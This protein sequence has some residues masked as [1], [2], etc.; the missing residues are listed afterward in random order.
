MKIGVM[1]K[2]E[3]TNDLLFH[4]ELFLASVLVVV[5]VHSFI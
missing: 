4:V 2:G 3:L 5:T 1:L